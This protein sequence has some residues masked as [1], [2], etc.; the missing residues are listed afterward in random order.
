MACGREESGSD[1]QDEHRSPAEPRGGGV[2]ARG[3]DGLRGDDRAG[4][5]DIHPEDFYRDRHRTI[6]EAIIRLNEAAS[7]V[8]VTVSEALAKHGNLEAVGG[9]DVVAA[10]RRRCRARQRPHYAQ[11]VKQ[12]ALM[13]RLDAAAKRIQQS[14]AE[15]DGE[16]TEMVEQAER[17]LFQ[18]AHEIA[19]PTSASSARSSTRRSTSS[20]RSPRAPPTRPGPYPASGSSTRSPAASSRAT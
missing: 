19:P 20:R 7:P 9:R 12:N 6:F 8:D 5:L 15:R 1:R 4:L 18:V 13:R 11:I 2:G 17:L 14:V 10:S 3:D 16:P